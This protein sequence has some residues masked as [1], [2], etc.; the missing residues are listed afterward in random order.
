M[1]GC[2]SIDTSYPGPGNYNSAKPLGTDACKFS[3]RGKGLVNNHNATSRS[4]GPGN[5]NYDSF[6][7]GKY[8]LSTNK[9]TQSVCFA[10]SKQ[11]RFNYQDFKVPGP[12]QYQMDPLI[13]GVGKI[14]N[15][16][17]KSN[18][19]VTISGRNEANIKKL[20]SGI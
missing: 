3:I 18:P 1:V 11:K 14:F 8:P 10:A 9:N 12:G 6:N 15:S 19:G 16:K 17:F 4:P 20:N 7:G 2:P 13:N 5:Y